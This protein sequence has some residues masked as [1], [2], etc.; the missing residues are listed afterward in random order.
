[1]LLRG[2]RVLYIDFEQS[3]DSVLARL[4][5]LGL[6]GEILERFAYLGLV[7]V[8]KTHEEAMA[9]ARKLHW[10]LKH[11]KVADQFM[12]IPGYSDI[13]ARAAALRQRAEGGP[14]ATPVAH[15]A[16]ASVEDLTKDGFFFAGTPDEVA[17]QIAAFNEGVGGFG[18]FLAMVQGGTMGYELTA[19]SMELLATQVMP[20]LK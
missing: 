7:F 17:E 20:Q 16:H 12:D 10:Y 13:Y 9:G 8:G 5:Q 11:N 19:G 3:R 6:R 18:H 2:G 14:L 1:M 4:H 15:L